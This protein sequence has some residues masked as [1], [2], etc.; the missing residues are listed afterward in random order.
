MKSGV[1]GWKLGNW[2]GGRCSVQ[3]RRN[4]VCTRMGE[5]DVGLA[6]H[7]CQVWGRNA[8]VASQGLLP[9]VLGVGYL[10]DPVE[11]STRQLEMSPQFTV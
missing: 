5:R 9:G 7:C 10:L 8:L 3:V 11:M 2:L 6:V 4:G 1:G